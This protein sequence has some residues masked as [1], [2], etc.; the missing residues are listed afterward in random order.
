M[1]YLPTINLWDPAI[2]AALLNNQLKLQPGQWVKCGG[3]KPS[4]FVRISKGRSIQAVHPYGEYGISNE[5]FKQALAC[6]PR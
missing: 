4:R 1:K 6:W 5:R 2:A 3:D